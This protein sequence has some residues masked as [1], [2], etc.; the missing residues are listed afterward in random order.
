MNK[1]KFAALI[2]AACIATP[3]IGADTPNLP[4]TPEQ[5]GVNEMLDVKTVLMPF[6]QAIIS[7]NVESMVVNYAFKEGEIFKKNDVI[8]KLDDRSI[9]QKY[10]RALASANESLASFTFA[11]RNYENTKNLLEKTIASAMDV[12]RA[13]LEVDVNM[14]KKQFNEANLALAKIELD[15]CNITAPFDGRL[16]QKL[17]QEFEYVRVGQQLLHI[18]DDTKLLA[19]MYIPSNQ[20]QKV[21]LGDKVKLFI[22]EKNVSYIG[23]IYAIAGD[24]DPASRTFEI[25]I[26][27]DNSRGELIPGMSGRYQGLQQ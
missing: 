22:D 21:K 8:A 19:V 23:E 1:F 4:I 16:K 5:P 25:R 3:F 2:A 18:I 26:L 12:E 24:I 17:V 9:R 20:A 10:Q 14:A 11:Q 6:R 7:S 27:V 13:Q 15:E